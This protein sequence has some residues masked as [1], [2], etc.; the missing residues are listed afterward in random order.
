MSDRDPLERYRGKR[1]FDTTAEPSGGD[2]R[3][4]DEP[5]YV[6]QIH[7]ASRTHF[8]FRLEV[9][10]VLKSW[11]VPKGPSTRPG[12]KRLAV[13][14]E[15]HPLEYREYE[16][17]IP[18]GEYGGGTVIVWDEGTYRPLAGHR[19]GRA[20]SFGEA[21]AHGHASFWLDGAKLRGGYAL[22]RI[23]SGE[24]GDEE[25][26]L[27]VKEKDSAARSD[28]PATPDPYRA[29][30]A[31]SGRTFHQVAEDESASGG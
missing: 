9:D 26:W 3:A 21:L 16:G 31:R 14:T 13:P 20:G 10:G 30:S 28:G 25:A 12:D 24:D 4:G 27:L 7:D 8:D 11:A 19:P 17:V 23:R 29:R 5:S 18:S 2:A 15:D 1:H 6:V 22:T